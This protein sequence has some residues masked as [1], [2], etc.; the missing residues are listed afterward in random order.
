MAGVPAE[1]IYRAMAEQ[2]G[3]PILGASATTLGI[4]RGRDIVP[5][6]AGLVLR[7]AFSPRGANGLSCAPTIL[8]LPPFALP[9]VWGGLNRYTF[10]WRLDPVDLGADLTARD[11][12]VPGSLRRHISIG[13]S[14]TM[15]YD[16]FV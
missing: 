16:D 13:P 9:L 3:V 11:D 2:N 5:D 12:S 8:E 6:N 10:V 7:P 4:R 14:R 1:G 15:G